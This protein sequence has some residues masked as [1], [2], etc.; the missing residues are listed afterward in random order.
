M[1]AISHASPSNKGFLHAGLTKAYR[2]FSER[3][4]L[5]VLTLEGQRAALGMR[6][7]DR[8]PDC[9]AASMARHSHHT[10]K[11]SPKSSVS[12]SGQSLMQVQCMGAWLIDLV[13]QSN[14]QG[15]N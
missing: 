1:I 6:T 5:P 15:W 4:W 10:N 9:R 14:G 12:A 13:Q 11:S 2:A 7:H 3:C 8:C